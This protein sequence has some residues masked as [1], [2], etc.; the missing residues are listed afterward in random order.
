MR[1]LCF[2]A[3]LYATGLAWMAQATT[4]VELNLSAGVL[5]GFGLAGCSFPMV[6]G[7]LGKLVPETGAVS[8]SVPG[9]RRARSASSSIRHSRPR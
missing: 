9:R 3:I 4:L 2:G 1:V 6:I 7:A 8:P 5:I